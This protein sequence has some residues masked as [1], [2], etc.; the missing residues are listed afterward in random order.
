[1]SCYCGNGC[2]EDKCLSTLTF[3]VDGT[4]LVP[5]LNG[6]PLNPIDL[7]YLV[8]ESETDT[9]LQLD[10]INKQ[11]IYTSESAANNVSSPDGISVSTLASLINISDLG[12]VEYPVATDGDI[13]SWDE[14][15]SKWISYTVPSGTIVTPVGIDADGKL[16]K[17]GSP[18]PAPAPDTVPLGGILIWPSATSDIPLSYRECNGQTLSRSVYSNLFDI[19]GTRYGSGDGSTSFNLPNMQ[20]RT[21]A[22]L[23]S[24]GTIDTQ[25]QDVGQTGGSKT[26]SL[27]G[28]QNGPHSHSGN[29]SGAGGHTHRLS[30]DIAMTY[31]GNQRLQINGGGQAFTFGGNP[32]AAVGNHAHS[33][34]TN[35]SGSGSPHNNLQPY[36][37]M[38]YIM[39]V[40]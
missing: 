13:I 28:A 30:R 5:R 35:S 36:I 4:D 40:V 22:G 32:I 31:G 21:V 10:S 18:G 6:V 29:T 3:I 23:S 2:E 33:F 17:S 25:F 8:R 39:R 27:T 20:T 9:R 15:L 19:I 38:P 24:S 11:I 26:V 7:K 12:D 34:T 37:T 14:T 1:M 16:V